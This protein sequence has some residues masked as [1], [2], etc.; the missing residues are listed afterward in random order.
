MHL[1]CQACA[2]GQ[3]HTVSEEWVSFPV[4]TKKQQVVQGYFVYT[5]YFVYI[6]YFVYKAYF[7]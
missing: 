3:D 4:L 1:A 2:V 7:V 6:V 5:V